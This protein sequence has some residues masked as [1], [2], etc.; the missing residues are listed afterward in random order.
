VTE[1]GWG[2]VYWGTGGLWKL[3]EDGATCGAHEARKRTERNAGGGGVGHAAAV[4]GLGSR[5]GFAAVA[6]DVGFPAGKC[7]GG[8]AGGQAVR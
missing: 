7:V 8:R 5:S 4:A 6:A 1:H 3:R 2:G